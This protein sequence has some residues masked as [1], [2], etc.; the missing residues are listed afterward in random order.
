MEAPV[1][2]NEKKL[3]SASPWTIHILIACLRQ[4]K[5][6]YSVSAKGETRSA[7]F[8]PYLFIAFAL[9][10]AASLKL[11]SCHANQNISN[12]LKILLLLIYH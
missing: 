12:G 11:I 7:A 2:R 6:V 8:V 4:S 9:Y 1:K 3:Y 5:G 10:I